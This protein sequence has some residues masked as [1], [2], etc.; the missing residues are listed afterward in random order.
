M[1]RAQSPPLT[2]QGRPF[3]QDQS[4]VWN[5]IRLIRISLLML[6][7]RLLMGAIVRPQSAAMKRELDQDMS[8]L[9]GEIIALKKTL[10]KLF[11]VLLASALN[12]RTERR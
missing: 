2:S 4:L 12:W 9:S 1:S 6:R 8:G 11:C 7:V 10:F 3:A 5:S